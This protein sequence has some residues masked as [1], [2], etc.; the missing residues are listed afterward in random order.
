MKNAIVGINSKYIHP[1]FGAHQIKINCPYQLDLF[2]VNIKDDFQKII[3]DLRNYDLI[4]F[5]VYIWNI[6]Y[7]KNILSNNFKDK[8]IVLGGPE[9]S[10][11]FDSLFRFPQVKY[12]ISGE[13]EEAFPELIEYLEGKKDINE[14]SN[15]YYISDN[16]IKYTH[17][18]LPDI[19]RIKHDYTLTKDFN[20]KI[21]YV[22][23]SRGCYFNCTYC[24]A[25]TE[26]PVREFPIEEVKENLLFL[27]NNNAKII[28]FL[29]RSF[30]INQKRTLEILKFIGTHDNNYTTFQFEVVGDRL[31]EEIIDY[32]KTLRPHFIRFEIGIQSTN[33]LTMDAIKRKQDFN[34]L[35]NNI[36]KIKDYIT[37]HTDLICGLPYEDLESFKN[38][39]N[40]TFMLFTE[41]LQLG[42][43]KELKGT[44]ISNTKE[45]HEYLFSPNSPYEVIKNKYMSNN[46]I[47]EVKKVEKVV[48]K[49]YNF[50]K[51]QKTFSYLFIDLKMNPYETF[52]KISNYIDCNGSFRDQLH[53]LTKNL[54]LSL[55]SLVDDKEL[56]LYK[57]KQDYLSMFR[58]KPTIWWDQD[59]TR[60]ERQ[61]I[62]EKVSSIYNI[63]IDTLY[64][65]ARLE[66]YKNEYFVIIYKDNKEIYYY[67][68]LI[69]PCGFDCSICPVYNKDCQGCINGNYSFCKICEIRNCGKKNNITICSSCKNYPCDKL[70]NISNE[71]KKLLDS[72]RK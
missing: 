7:I 38:S 56:L 19:T 39:F 53:I 15:L 29:D 61:I 44:E 48:D 12:I 62:Y 55:L 27:L 18:K 22:E 31:S 14:V 49:L 47:L 33:P 70:N 37:I 21:C 4:A 41:E 68:S 59:I 72:L 20:N 42:F 57:I 17:T 58:I 23:S 45:N 16:E 64:N 34:L 35:K 32:I 43:L 36:L 71:S 30:N 8:I 24:L 1:A 65:Y 25:S 2:E 69:S 52:L 46:D 51:F 50:S 9:A 10:F 54:Y 13:G 60:K 63:N 40:D 3:N 26:K 66:K 67:T 5:S 11:S 28:K 6:E